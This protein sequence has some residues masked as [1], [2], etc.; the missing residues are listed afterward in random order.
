MNIIH[1]KDVAT[2]FRETMELH[3]S[4]FGVT[5]SNFPSGACGDATLVLGTHLKDISLG[6][7]NYMVGNYHGIEENSW[8]SHVW[9]Q[10]GQLVIDIT[11]DQFPNVDDKVIVSNNSIWHSTLN[12]RALHLADY[13]IYDANTKCS[14]ERIHHKVLGFIK[15]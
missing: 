15:K 6:K 4:D 14:L 1:I 13:R 10:S 12:G 3:K 2:H 9:L 11:A 8:S 5:F 7:F